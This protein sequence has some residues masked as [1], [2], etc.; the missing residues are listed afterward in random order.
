MLTL[1][2]GFCGHSRG[3]SV[4]FSGR[5]CEVASGE[6]EPPGEAGGWDKD[7]SS[8]DVSTPRGFHAGVSF[9]C[10]LKATRPIMPIAA[11]A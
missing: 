1:T 10:R 8:R 4:R 5:E 6:P 3:L 9:V 7:S 11:K 2:P